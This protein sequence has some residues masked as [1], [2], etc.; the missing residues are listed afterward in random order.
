MSSNFHPDGTL[1]IVSGPSGA[2]K[3]TLIN[4]VRRQ[5]EPIG[6]RLHFSV[7]H[8]TRS[9]R[10]GET[11]GVSYHFV[12]REAFDDMVARGEFLEWAHVHDHQYGTSGQFTAIS[13]LTFSSVCPPSSGAS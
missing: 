5:L 9:R 13:S 2:G 10:E 6:I 12:S 7:S 8:T 3:T 1:F 4:E 11:E